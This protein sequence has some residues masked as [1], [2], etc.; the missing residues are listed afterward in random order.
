M[1]DGAI[2]ILDQIF[3]F[4]VNIARKNLPRTNLWQITAQ[5]IRAK[6]LAISVEKLSRREATY[7]DTLK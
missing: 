6:L 3:H 7:R 4:H 5:Y 1:R 2:K